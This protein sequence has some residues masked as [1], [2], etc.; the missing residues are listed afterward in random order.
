M[1]SLWFTNPIHF[2]LFLEHQTI[3][4]I[5]FFQLKDLSPQ[6]FQCIDLRY[7]NISD[8]EIRAIPPLISKLT[9]LQILILS[10][11]GL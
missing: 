7:L 8:N 10:K 5:F 11:N 6:L 4:D 1:L 3:S 9:N 2:S